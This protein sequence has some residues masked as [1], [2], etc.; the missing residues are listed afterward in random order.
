MIKDELLVG[1]CVDVFGIELAVKGL[2]D[3]PA[4]VVLWAEQVCPGQWL[5]LALALFF[6]CVRADEF[7]VWEG[8]VP[9]VHEDMVLCIVG[10]NVLYGAHLVDLAADIVGESYGGEDGYAAIL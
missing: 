2:V 1:V 7:G 3:V 8:F 5:F 10:S 4:G 6:Q 9:V